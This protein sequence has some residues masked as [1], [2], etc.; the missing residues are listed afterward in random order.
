MTH[1]TDVARVSVMAPADNHSPHIGLPS[2]FCWTKFGTEAGEATASIFERKE[3]ERQRNGGVFLWGIGS[4]IRPSLV[5]LL[6][7]T[8]YPEVIFSP[9][10]SAAAKRDVSPER[11]VLWTH[12][13]TYDGTPY[14]IPEYSLVTSRADSALS[15][16]SHFAL[17]CKSTEPLV[18]PSN[19]T[20]S[21][22]SVC[23][24]ELRNLRTGSTLGASQVTSV[25]RRVTSDRTSGAA[26]VNYPVAVRARLIYPYF[27]R[28]SKAFPIPDS[29]RLDR[30]TQQASREAM[31]ELLRCRREVAKAVKDSPRQLTFV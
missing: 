18:A 20:S 8:E 5:A 11:L 29:L 6:Q 12:A 27:V 14:E 25:V 3:I 31:E 2:V 28:L 30:P 4:S 15:K 13:D 19:V 10:K 22:G 16:K 21:Q 7:E 24:E 1:V 23:L 26:T 17:I 9:M